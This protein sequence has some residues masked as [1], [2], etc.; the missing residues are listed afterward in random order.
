MHG[1]SPCPGAGQLAL[2]ASG[3]EQQWEDGTPARAAFGLQ[4][5]GSAPRPWG[6]FGTVISRLPR[7]GLH[8]RRTV[9][10]VVGLVF[11]LETPKAAIHLRE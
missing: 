7:V 10:D 11:E 9:R 3:Q 4:S 1:I 6:I 8:R 2:L 5:A